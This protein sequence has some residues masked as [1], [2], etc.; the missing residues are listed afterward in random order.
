MS[1]PIKPYYIPPLEDWPL[2]TI[3]G[4]ATF[5]VGLR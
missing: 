1:N 5:T 3:E 4:D 2:M